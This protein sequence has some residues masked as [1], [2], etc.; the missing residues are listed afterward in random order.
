MRKTTPR[1]ALL[2]A[3]FLVGCSPVDDSA[4]PAPVS[5]LGV[6]QEPPSEIV[7][8]G[9]YFVSKECRRIGEDYALGIWGVCEVDK[10]LQGDMKLALLKDVHVPADIVEGR[11]YTS[12]WQI[13]DS[14]RERLRKAQ[15]GGFTG[16]W[17]DGE[18]LEVVPDGEPKR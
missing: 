18:T 1:C 12:R 2:S 16:M 17:L 8:R 5:E 11:L 4:E 15:E 3:F 10:V 7:F 9:R 13:S 14:D 6:V